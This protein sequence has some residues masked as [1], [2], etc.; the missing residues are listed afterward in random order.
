MSKSDYKYIRWTKYQGRRFWQAR[1]GSK[2]K[3]F[4]PTDEGERAA[5]KYSD[6]L[7]IK[8]GREPVNVLVRN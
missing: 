7:L 3:L 2:T 8:E 4:P 5:A 6:L 1:V